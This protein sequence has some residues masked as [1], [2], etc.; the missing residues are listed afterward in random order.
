[1]IDIRKAEECCGC[2]ACKAVCPVGCISMPADGEGF[3]YALADR[4]RCTGCGRC[5]EVCPVRNRFK[6]VAGRAAV[7][8]CAA[9]DDGLRMKSS[10][11]GVFGA[12]AREVIS[13]GGVVFGARFDFGGAREGAVP[14]FPV[15]VGHS[16]HEGP[17]PAAAP[18]L[19]HG[20]AVSEEELGPLM[21]SKYL[22]SDMGDAFRRAEEYLKAGRQVLFSGVPCQ[23]A[24]LTRFLGRDYDNLLKIDILCHDVPSPR[25][26]DKY[27]A[28]NFGRGIVSIDFRD[29]TT[30]WRDF[31]FTAVGSDGSSFSRRASVNPY[32]QGFLK[33]LYS[34]PS[35]G[36]C[37]ARSLSSG[38]DITLG[39][40]WGVRSWH[41][42]ID[43]NRGASVVFVASCRGAEAFENIRGRLRWERSEYR[44]A[45]VG[46]PNLKYSTR[47]NRNRA[48]FFANFENSD[49]NGLVARLAPESKLRK[50]EKRIGKAVLRWLA[51]I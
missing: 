44:K 40:Y 19:V 24:G 1:M 35:C 37:P 27:I 5:D 9:L 12:L 32:I 50:V 15:P 28:E 7:Y 17:A 13:Q 31:S 30:G 21:G 26:F 45:L 6:P 2:S 20:E 36:R 14:D 10:S 49:F 25:V 46:N 48:I 47:P 4:E 22:Q 18:R 34:R 33:G 3:P 29:K 11:G 51:K 8:A 23:L 41:P 43:D 39:D 42:G 16:T 38:S